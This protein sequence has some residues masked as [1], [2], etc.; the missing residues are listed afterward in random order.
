MFLGAQ[1]KFAYLSE[2]GRKVFYGET[3]FLHIAFNADPEAK[4]WFN[5]VFNLGGVFK[6]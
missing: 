4:S 3:F 1:Q 2:A 5:G 6:A